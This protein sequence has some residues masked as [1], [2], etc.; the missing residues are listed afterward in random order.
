MQH[1][2][3]FNKPILGEELKAEDS[4]LEK[5]DTSYSKTMTASMPVCGEG[6]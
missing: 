3:F 1:C 5:I 6:Y 4:T 2:I